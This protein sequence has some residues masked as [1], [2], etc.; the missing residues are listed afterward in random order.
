MQML[1]VKHLK[2]IEIDDLLVIREEAYKKIFD[3][4]TEIDEI[5][6]D[7]GLFDFDE[8]PYP[9][10]GLVKKAAKPKPNQRQSQWKTFQRSC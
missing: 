2:Q 5:C 3:I 8:P 10:A 1:S 9:V 4:E 6:G 7:E